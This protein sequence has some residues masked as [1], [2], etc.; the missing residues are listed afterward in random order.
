M[1]EVKKISEINAE[2]KELN[3]PR[4]EKAIKALISFIIS[5]AV[6]IGPIIL[7]V[8]LLIYRQYRGLLA[9]G[10]LAMTTILMIMV[11]KIYYESIVRKRVANINKLIIIPTMV[12]FVLGLALIYLMAKVGTI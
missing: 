8:N 7:F 5:L 12:V 11:Q 2:I 4:K 10:I 9:L 1:M 6:V 3:V